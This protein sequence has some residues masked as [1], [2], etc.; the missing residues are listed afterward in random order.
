[1]PFK[2]LSAM[3][4]AELVKELCNREGVEASYVG[5]YESFNADCTGPVV[6]LIVED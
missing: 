2:D 1:M 4:T 3:S 5:P 6:V